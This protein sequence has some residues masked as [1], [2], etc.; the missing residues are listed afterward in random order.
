MLDLAVLV[1]AFHMP[2]AVWGVTVL[3]AYA[4]IPLVLLLRFNVDSSQ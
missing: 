3:P 2:W 4:L 1:G